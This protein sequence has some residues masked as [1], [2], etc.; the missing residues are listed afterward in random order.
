[1]SKWLKTLY[2]WVQSVLE[3]SSSVN[4]IQKASSGVPVALE[5]VQSSP[6]IHMG[7]IIFVS[8]MSSLLQF[9]VVDLV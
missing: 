1:M 5:I 6:Y 8:S 3:M 7:K 4:E 9:A 2:P